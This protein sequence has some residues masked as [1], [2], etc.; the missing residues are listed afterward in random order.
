MKQRITK[1]QLKEL[2]KEQLKKLMEW[3]EPIQSLDVIQVDGLIYYLCE[4]EH[5]TAKEILP[6]LNIGQMIEFL[7]DYIDILDLREKWTVREMI[8]GMKLYEYDELCDALWEAVKEKLKS[9]E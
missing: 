9:Q 2:N 4:L 6:L 8:P 3:W 7:G 1:K 5:I